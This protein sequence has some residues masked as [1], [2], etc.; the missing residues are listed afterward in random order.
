[1]TSKRP[2]H[3]QNQQLEGTRE[4]WNGQLQE[5]AHYPPQADSELLPQTDKTDNPEVYQPISFV[6]TITCI[7]GL[8]QVTTCKTEGLQER[9]LW[10]QR[11]AAYQQIHTGRHQGVDQENTS[12]WLRRTSLKAETEGLIIAV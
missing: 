8:E 12:Q 3:Q 7:P 10:M 5:P 2:L 6:P 1:M 11:S 4:R 9:M